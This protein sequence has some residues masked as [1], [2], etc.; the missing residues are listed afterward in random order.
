MNDNYSKNTLEKINEL[1]RL[2]MSLRGRQAKLVKQLVVISMLT[3]I[4]S[5]ILFRNYW[6]TAWFAIISVTFS[7]TIHTDTISKKFTA[8]ANEVKSKLLEAL[9]H[10]YHPEI[11]HLF[12]TSPSR[13]YKHFERIKSGTLQFMDEEDVIV[14]ELKNTKFYLSEIKL[15]DDKEIFSGILFHFELDKLCFPSSSIWGTSI[16]VSERKDVRSFKNYP[17]NFTTKDINIFEQS[18]GLFL[19]LIAH[20]S[21]RSGKLRMQLDGNKITI[22][23]PTKMKFLDTPAFELKRKFNHK[24]YFEVLGKQV[25]SLFYILEAFALK[26]EGGAMIDERLEIIAQKMLRED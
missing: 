8:L 16:D 23:L 17:L 21:K 25:N 15:M 4:V 2:R 13:G 22:V 26:E 14:G 9:I 19:G 24:K 20:L 1:D 5:A 7:Y 10:E 3:I 11:N 12:K 18:I 6:F